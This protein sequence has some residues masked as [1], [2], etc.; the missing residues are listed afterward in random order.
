MIKL[1]DFSNLIDVD[2]IKN[3]LEDGE[4][5]WYFQ[6]KTVDYGYDSSRKDENTILNSQL[7]HTFFNGRVTSETIN[8]VTPILSNVDVGVA[9]KL[10]RIKSNFNHNITNY[11]KKN[12]GAIH[13]DY[14]TKNKN[15]IVNVENNYMSLLYYVND[16]DGDTRF[17]QDKKIIYQHTPKK[18]TALLFN[19]NLEHAGSNPIIS[20]HRMVINFIF[21]NLFDIKE[22]LKEYEIMTDGIRHG[23]GSF[24][25]HNKSVY[26]ILKS[27][28]L[29]E[30]LCLAGLYHSVYGTEFFKPNLNINRDIISNKIGSYAENLVFNFCNLKNRDY[31]ILEI[32]DKDLQYIAYANLLCQDNKNEKI[33]NL[34]RKYKNQLGLY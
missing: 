29:N 12:Y 3:C 13:T 16:S 4:F 7:S 21:K 22:T 6:K 31:T 5:A 25:K 15:K 24:Y 11:N 9:K 20:N 2:K 17:F 18:G 26:D 27:L 30:D 14:F 33:E 8:M 10:Y 32:K 23:D 34:I 1:F 28:K 19:S